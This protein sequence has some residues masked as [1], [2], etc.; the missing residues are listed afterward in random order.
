MGKHSGPAYKATPDNLTYTLTPRSRTLAATGGIIAYT[1][2][3]D[4][5]RDLE[6]EDAKFRAYLAEHGF[7]TDFGESLEQNIKASAFKI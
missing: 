7:S 1:L 6:D 4:R 5:S 2:I 3:P